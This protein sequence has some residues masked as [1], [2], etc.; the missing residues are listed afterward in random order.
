GPPPGALG[1][2]AWEQMVARGGDRVLAVGRVEGLRHGGALRAL[3][4]LEAVLGDGVRV[5]SWEA[6]GPAMRELALV[7]V[8]PLTIAVVIGVAV[9]MGWAFRSAMLAGVGLAALGF[10]G[11]ALMSVMRL[12]GW[13]WNL[14]NFLAIPLLL[15]MGVDYAI[16][17]ILALKRHDG[18]L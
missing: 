11:L 2:W 14:M 10:A 1:E 9:T 6:L 5:G 17:L 15:G 3:R 7:R 16:H 12:A 4:A 8:L 18:D 13:S